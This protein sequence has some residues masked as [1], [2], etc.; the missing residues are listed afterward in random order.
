[1]IRHS[2]RRELLAD[3]FGAQGLSTLSYM[4]QKLELA[5]KLYSLLPTVSFTK[6]AAT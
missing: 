5:Q 1:M 6:M 3:V 4:Q 2:R